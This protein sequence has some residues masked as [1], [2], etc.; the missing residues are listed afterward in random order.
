MKKLMV[1]LAC[2]LGLS[3]ANAAAI[4]WATGAAMKP[5][6]SA[7]SA[8]GDIKMYVFEVA[9]GDYDGL[10]E[11]IISQMDVS[12]AALSGATTKSSSGITLVDSATYKPGNTVYAAVLLTAKGADGNDYYIAQKMTAGPVDDMDSNISFSSLAKKNY[13]TG[14][15]VTWTQMG[16]DVP[17]PTSGLLLLLGVAG[18]A[19]RRKAK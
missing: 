9:A 16:G 14:A 10:T 7:Y 8:A 3:V 6:G 4:T 2:G 18:L 19:L 13:M 11:D 12:T 1:M 5:D 17:E 15:A